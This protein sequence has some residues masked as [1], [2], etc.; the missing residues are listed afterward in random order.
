LR[1]AILPGV[2]LGA[3]CVVGI[4]SVVTHSF[5]AYSMIAGSPARLIKC[6]SKESGLWLPVAG[7][8]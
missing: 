6:W 5:P 2:R 3:H 4:N 7:V 1:S 8:R